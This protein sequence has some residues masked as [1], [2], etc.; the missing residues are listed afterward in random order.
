MEHSYGLESV[1]SQSIHYNKHIDFIQ[2]WEGY[3]L[4]ENLIGIQ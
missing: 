2:L 4:M 3:N 1:P